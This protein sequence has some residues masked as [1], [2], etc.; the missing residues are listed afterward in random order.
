MKPQISIIVCTYNG[1]ELLKKCILSILNQ[2]YKN[3]E[4]LFIDGGSSDGTLEY[5]KKIIKKDARIKLIKNKRRLPEGRGMGKWLGFIK[6]QGIIFGI[7]DQDNI[8]QKN[9]VLSTA[10]KILKKDKQVMLVTSG[11]KNSRRTAHITRYVSLYG[12]DSFLAYRSLDF[13]RRLKENK[14]IEQFIAKKDNQTLVGSNNV[15]YLRSALK[16]VGGYERDVTT[17]LKLLISGKDKIYVINNA[18]EHYSDK[19]LYSLAIKKFKWGKNYFK[20]NNNKDQY[21]YFPKTSLEL[22]EFLKAISFGVLF[23]PNF[24]YAYK[25]YKNS[26]DFL[27]FI[28]PYM[29]F[30]NILAYGLNFIINKIK[31]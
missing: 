2:D 17:N 20:S 31:T 27:A 28:F 30:A 15:F 7:I 5:L 26:K 22:K 16:K 1:G 25:V 14:E 24:Y 11:L 4:L 6:S 8:L 12:T 21:D 3:F 18:T 23:I 29:A 13:L 9:N 10:E 19:N